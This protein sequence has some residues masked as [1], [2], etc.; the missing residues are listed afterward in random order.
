M[1]RRRGELRDQLWAT[2]WKEINTVLPW[3]MLGPVNVLIFEYLDEA[4]GLFRD[5]PI[6]MTSCRHPIRNYLWQELFSLVQ[7]RYTVEVWSLPNRRIYLHLLGII[8]RLSIRW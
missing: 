6:G 4:H 3:R 2:I 1:S 5:F 8:D 7:K